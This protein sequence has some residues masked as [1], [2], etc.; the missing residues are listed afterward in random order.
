MIMAKT[1]TPAKVRDMINPYR[2]DCVLLI[3][4]D[5]I[6]NFLNEDIL[7]TL[8]LSHSIKS[9]KSVE[10]AMTFLT[11]SYSTKSNS[12]ILIFLDLIMSSHSKD[13]FDFLEELFVRSEI[14]ASNIDIIVLTNSLNNINRQKAEKYHIM[15]Y[16]AKPLSTEKVRA[17]L[18]K[19]LKLNF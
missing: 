1:L 15:D 14:P 8:K 11:Y 10:E 2:Y 19:R 3:D 9:S 4:D 17:S 16:V 6:T 18:G 12:S 13:G 5:D 7:K